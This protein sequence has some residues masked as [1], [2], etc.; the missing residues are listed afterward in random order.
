MAGPKDSPGTCGS[1]RERDDHWNDVLSAKRVVVKVGTSSLVRGDGKFDLEVMK[2]LAHDLEWL[3]ARGNQVALVSSGAVVAGLEALGL[4]ERPRDVVTQQ[5]LAAVGNPLL[6]A[7][8]ARFFTA[9]PIAQVLLTQENLSNRRSFN[10]FRDAI[11]RMLGMDIVPVINEN[12]VV[13]IDELTHPEGVEFN[14]SDNDVLAALVT[15]SIHAD[16]LL[17]LSDTDGLYTKHPNS[18]YAEFVPLVRKITP[19][20]KAMGRSGSGKVG[21]GGMASKIYAAEIAGRAGA[22]AL[23]VNA[24]TTRVREIFS[25]GAGVGTLFL[26]GAKLPDKKLWILYASSPKGRLFVDEGARRALVDGGASLLV[27][28]I[29]GVKGKFAAGDVVTLCG[30]DGAPFANGIANYSAAEVRRVL[31]MPREVQVEFIKMAELRE[32]IGRDS[33]TFF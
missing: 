11:E 16:L 8:Y 30:P 22:H 28:G 31:A 10:H 15:A 20:V 32:V 4:E 9:H 14:F 29:T 23:I 25:E 24:K 12:D 17:L 5:V 18:P 19:R 21:R 13:S 6:V 7:A 27:R 3:K 33:M 1:E 2:R 26:P